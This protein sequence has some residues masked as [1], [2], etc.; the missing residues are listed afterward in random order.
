MRIVLDT[1]YLQCAIAGGADCIVTGN[2]RHFPPKLCRGVSV[3][4]PRRF[5]DQ[6]AAQGDDIP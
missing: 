2:T 5:L 3:L 1:R 6:L 4:T